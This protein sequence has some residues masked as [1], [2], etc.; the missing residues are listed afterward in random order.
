M[1][2]FDNFSLNLTEKDIYLNSFTLIK[3]LNK[4]Q[5]YI[6]KYIFVF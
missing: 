1:Y 5:Y 4:I 3:Y 6:I 2:T